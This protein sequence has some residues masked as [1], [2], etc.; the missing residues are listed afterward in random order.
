MDVI[1]AA[2]DDLDDDFALPFADQ[3]AAEAA[4][5]AA[6][7]HVA[8]VS[9]AQVS[10]SSV[11]RDQPV[12]VS[13]LSS[14]SGRA[15]F[16]SV[17]RLWDPIS[18]DPWNLLSRALHE[19]HPLMYLGNPP[20]RRLRRKRGQSLVTLVKKL[21]KNRQY[22]S[23]RL[24]HSEVCA[25]RDEFVRRYVEASAQPWASLVRQAKRVFNE[26]SWE[27][28]NAWTVVNRV[29]KLMFKV[30]R[31][32]GRKVIDPPA[33]AWLPQTSTGDADNRVQGSLEV[34][35]CLVSW[36]TDFGLG[37]PALRS[38]VEHRQAALSSAGPP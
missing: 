38:L 14:S 11:L 2:A 10:L 7:D 22:M 25:A 37:E 16:D 4:P 26:Q 21:H 6:F 18:L 30:I 1:S 32:H 8:F 36:N 31:G 20:R 13:G 33:H 19:H 35:G 24:P 34:F 15:V 9:P 12:N 3:H 23:W 17:Q 27:F 5:D 29:S 28:K